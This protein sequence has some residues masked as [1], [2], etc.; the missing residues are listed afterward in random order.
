MQPDEIM[1]ALK[2]KN[3]RIYEDLQQP[4]TI[5]ETLEAAAKNVRIEGVVK[6]CKAPNF[7]MQA[8]KI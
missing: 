3:L 1:Q 6:S 8:I 4:D 5:T 7:L 2:A